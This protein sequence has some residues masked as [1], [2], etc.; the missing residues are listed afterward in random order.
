MSMI[1]VGDETNMSN[2]CDWTL[3]D[4]DEGSFNTGCHKTF[5]LIDGTPRDNDMYYCPMCGRALHYEP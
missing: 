5:V 3:D 2:R 1:P 4:G